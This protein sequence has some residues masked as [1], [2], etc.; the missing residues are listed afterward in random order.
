MKTEDIKRIEQTTSKDEANEYLAKG[1][2]IVR[3]FSTKKKMGDSETIEPM[4]VLGLVG[5]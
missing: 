1:Y 2:K 3:I 4:Y 5:E